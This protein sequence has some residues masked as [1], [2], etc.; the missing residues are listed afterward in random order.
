MSQGFRIDV[1]KKNEKKRMKRKEKATTDVYFKQ[2]MH[3][4]KQLLPK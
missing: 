4:Q 3:M 1:K 2:E